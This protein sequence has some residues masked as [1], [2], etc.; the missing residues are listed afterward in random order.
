MI[1]VVPVP[2]GQIRS[3]V[4]SGG[5]LYKLVK[6]TGDTPFQD[7]ID[8]GELVT[9]FEEDKEK[10][11]PGRK[12]IDKEKICQ[13]FKEGYTTKDIAGEV[14]CSIPTAINVL[15]EKELWPKTKGGK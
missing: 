14:N 3:F 15:K 4:N 11:K 7:V 12:K 5:Q 10:E 2:F 13:L 9:L 6:I 1:K 8:A